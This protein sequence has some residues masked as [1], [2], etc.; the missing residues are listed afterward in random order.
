MHLLG[1]V[2]RKRPEENAKGL[3][4]CIILFPHRPADVRV[5]QLRLFLLHR[6]QGG[7]APHRTVVEQVPVLKGKPE[8]RAGREGLPKDRNPSG[9]GVSQPLQPHAKELGITVVDHDHVVQHR[10]ATFLGQPHVERKIVL[11]TFPT[12][13]R[14]LNAPVASLS[15][16]LCQGH[17]ELIR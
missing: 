12:S 10:S 6:T 7:L 2:H 3:W 4:A 13:L 8:G 11:G 5:G 9:V 16:H 15:E 14:Q 1:D 17:I